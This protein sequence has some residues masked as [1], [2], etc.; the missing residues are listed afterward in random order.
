MTDVDEQQLR[1]LLFRS[2][3]GDQAGFATLYEYTAARLYAV[4]LHLLGQREAAE[5]AVQETYVRIWHQ[6]ASY[7]PTRGS[8]MTWMI[9]IARYRAI[10]QM[11]RRGRRPESDFEAMP[12]GALRDAA[13]GPQETAALN[14]DANALAECMDVLS[15]DQ[16]QAIQLAFL[17]GLTHEQVGN[18]LGS[19]LGSVKSWIRRGL[20]ALKRCLQS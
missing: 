5:E 6:A 4:C 11:R 10:D 12:E 19:P 8:V 7:S 13:A 14:S 18:R 20:Q 3:H 2:G 9:S 16:R 17:Q 15:A 1:R